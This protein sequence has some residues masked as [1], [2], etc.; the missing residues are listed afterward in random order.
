M[1]VAKQNPEHA[2]LLI[3]LLEKEGVVFNGEIFTHNG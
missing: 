2:K 1:K 3:S